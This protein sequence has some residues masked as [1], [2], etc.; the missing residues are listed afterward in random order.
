MC[1]GGG[2]FHFP[3]F[4]LSLELHVYNVWQ[5]ASRALDQPR[6]GGEREKLGTCLTARPP[7]DAGVV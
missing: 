1:G 4:V 7:P 3:F 6:G 5:D 2:R